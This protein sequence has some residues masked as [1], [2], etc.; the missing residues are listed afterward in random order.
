MQ[1]SSPLRM[2]R[3]TDPGDRA[4]LGDEARLVLALLAD[5][6]RPRPRPVLRE[7]EHGALLD[8]RLGE[9]AVVCHGALYCVN[10]VIMQLKAVEP[11]GLQQRFFSF[12]AASGISVG[13]RT[14]TVPL[15]AK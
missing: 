6:D 5:P 8:Q 7:G 9:V 1:S 15:I 12:G 13:K 4:E 14:S 10:A 2:A 3:P 11:D